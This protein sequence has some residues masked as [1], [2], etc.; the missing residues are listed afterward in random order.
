MQ[1]N[2]IL[3]SLYDTTLFVAIHSKI[4]IKVNHKISQ[5][6]KNCGIA[7]EKLFSVFD[8]CWRKWWF[9]VQDVDYKD[10]KACVSLVVPLQCDTRGC[11]LTEESMKCLLEA[12]QHKVLLEELQ[13]VYEESGDIDQTALAL[14]HLRWAYKMHLLHSG[15]ILF[16]S[17]LSRSVSRFFYKH[18]WREWDEE[19]EDDDFDYFVRC[20]EPRLR[21][22]VHCASLLIGK[23]RLPWVFFVKC[24][25]FQL[26]WHVGGQSSSRP[27]SRVSDIT[28]ELLPVLSGVFC[29]AQ[30]PQQWLRLWGG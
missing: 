21:L 13:V 17:S 29:A 25:S 12:T 9:Q 8:L 18:I 14:E 11:E 24:V 16:I 10:L 30:W 26:L 3:I 7:Q 15:A 1:E 23:D 5:I 27:C 6:I 22:W 20:V 28:A 2:C 4:S 19:D